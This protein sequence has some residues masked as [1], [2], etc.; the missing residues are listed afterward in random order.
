MEIYEASKEAYNAV[1]NVKRRR[2]PK[3]LTPGTLKEYQ[4]GFM[5]SEFCSGSVSINRC[6][7]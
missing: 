1:N 6:S 4:E 3:M 5:T 7:K 2:H